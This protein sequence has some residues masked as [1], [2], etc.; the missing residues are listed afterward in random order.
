MRRRLAIGI[1]TILA[2]LGLIVPLAQAVGP[3]T[4]TRSCSTFHFSLYQDPNE[5]GPS[6]E[7]NTTTSGQCWV[8][9]ANLTTTVFDGNWNDRADS[10]WVLEMPSNYILKLYKDI[11]FG[12]FC[13]AVVGGANFP[14]TTRYIHQLGND[15]CHD[16]ISSYNFYKT[17]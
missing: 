5:G 4:G 10:V 1:A 12:N 16:N 7:N 9:D 11:N 17:D 13:T 14:G 3:I 8:A 2:A 6:Y 15:G